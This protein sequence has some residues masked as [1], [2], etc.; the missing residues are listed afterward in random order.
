MEKGPT[1]VVTGQVM[2]GKIVVP[3]ETIFGVSVTIEKDAYTCMLS[4][5]IDVF[6][7]SF[8]F[9]LFAVTLVYLSR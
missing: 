3:V 2:G 5:P 6:H 9:S 4:Y 8:Q 1:Y 7:L